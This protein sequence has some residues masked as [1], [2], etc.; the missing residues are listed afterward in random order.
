MLSPII[1]RWELLVRIGGLTNDSHH[2]QCLRLD[3]DDADDAVDAVDAPST[4]VAK[5][6][7]K[8]SNPVFFNSNF[9]I[10]NSSWIMISNPT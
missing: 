2:L 5:K 1:G 8:D 6:F 4:I 3:A 9:F 10:V 7:S